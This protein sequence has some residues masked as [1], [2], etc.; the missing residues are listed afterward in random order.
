VKF[1][2]SWCGV[3]VRCRVAVLLTKQVSLEDSIDDV[4]VIQHPY[5]TV[6]SIGMLFGRDGREYVEQF[7]VRPGLLRKE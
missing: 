1:I 4:D 7:V 2:Q 6:Q 3:S 5:G